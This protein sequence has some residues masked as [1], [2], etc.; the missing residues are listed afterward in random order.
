[1]KRWALIVFIFKMFLF[2]IMG[3]GISSA[4]LTKHSQILFLRL[5]FQNSQADQNPFHI[6]VVC[7]HSFLI[8]EFVALFCFRRYREKL[9]VYCEDI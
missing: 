7:I 6:I 2:I 1:M 5:A 8:A 4:T 3:I 9:K